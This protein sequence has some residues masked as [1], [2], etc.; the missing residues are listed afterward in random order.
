MNFFAGFRMGRP[1]AIMASVTQCLSSRSDLLKMISIALNR[2]FHYLVR[3]NKDLA[4]QQGE[5]Y[6]LRNHDSEAVP[7]FSAVTPAFNEVES[8][9]ELVERI[10]AVFSTGFSKPQSYELIIVDDG[11]TDGTRD[12]L[13]ELS[14]QRSQVRPIIL[15][16]N[17]GKSM[18]LMTG[19]LNA[20]GRCIVTLDADLQDNPEEI[21]D[22]VAKLAEGYH[23][24]GGCRQ[25]RQDTAIRKLGSLVFNWTV[26]KAA[27]LDIKDLNCGFKV[28]RAEVIKTIA[29]YGQF[30][31]YIPLLAHFA[32][33]KVAEHPVRN[34]ARKHGTTKYPTLR[35][36]GLFDLLTILVIHKYNLSPLHFFA[37]IAA[38]FA[39]PSG[40]VL[41]YFVT[42]HLLSAIGIGGDFL[43]TER[44]LLSISLTM[45]LIGVNVF[46]T[47]F[48]CD[49]VLHH[50]IR[51]RIDRMSELNVEEHINAPEQHSHPAGRSE[52]LFQSPADVD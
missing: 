16:R 27:G 20:R 43:I 33:F 4:R 21:P 30:H 15:R 47:G 45:F 48:V 18:A 51:G 8:I 31:R 32:G 37:K 12:L 14:E 49:F 17:A 25:R 50:L 38:L 10:D 13:K 11:S 19:F 26:R 7:V 1:V 39:I 44:P 40:A 5:A 41:G 23:L 35:Y 36:Q 34:S 6:E 29:V 42:R 52:D 2:A 28:Y 3:R 24:V 22:L 9:P 46:L